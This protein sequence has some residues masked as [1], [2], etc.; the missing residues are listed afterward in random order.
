MHLGFYNEFFP[1]VNYQT[2]YS[3]DP[4]ML[5]RGFQMQRSKKREKERFLCI[6]GIFARTE[7]PTIRALKCVVKQIFNALNEQ[8]FLQ[9][10]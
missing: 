2:G 7:P 5:R 8:V 3:T 10:G 4:W 6:Y 1:M 9:Q